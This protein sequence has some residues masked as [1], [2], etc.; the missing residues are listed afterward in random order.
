M[1]NLFLYHKIL[2]IKEFLEILLDMILFYLR[3]LVQKSYYFIRELIKVHQYIFI[4]KNLSNS[5]TFISILISMPNKLNHDQNLSFEGF[6]KAFI[7]FFI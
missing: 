5:Q 6:I 2:K 1:E 7:I 4:S 3:K